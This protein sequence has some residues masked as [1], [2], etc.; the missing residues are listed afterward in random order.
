MNISVFVTVLFV[1]S[2]IMKM[3][4]IVRWKW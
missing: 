3:E 2:V 4:C 1:D